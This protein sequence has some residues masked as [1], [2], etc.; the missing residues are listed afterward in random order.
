MEFFLAQ[1]FATEFFF[2]K[3]TFKNEKEVT[4]FAK[5]MW[6]KWTLNKPSDVWDSVA[7]GM[8]RIFRDESLRLCV[9]MR[10]RSISRKTVNK[11]LEQT[12]SLSSNTTEQK[13]VKE[14]T[15]S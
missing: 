9:Y 4:L 10:T 11:G 1:S 12:G 13:T 14:K 2:D 3:V 15:A 6:W 5:R 7:T 8:R